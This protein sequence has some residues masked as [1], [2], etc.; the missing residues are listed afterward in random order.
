MFGRDASIK[1]HFRD[2]Y[3]DPKNLQ[4]YIDSVASNND[5]PALDKALFEAKVLFESDFAR[6]DAQKV[7]SV[8]FFRFIIFFF[9]FTFC[10]KMKRK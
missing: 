1:L 4:T 9:T 6:K 3:S 10:A 7:S 8:V 5:E 2:K